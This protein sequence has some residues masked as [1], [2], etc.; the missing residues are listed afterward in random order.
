MAWLRI[1]YA[2]LTWAAC[3][4]YWLELLMAKAMYCIKQRDLRSS[5]KTDS[6]ITICICVLENIRHR[7][8]INF[9][10]ISSIDLSTFVALGQQTICTLPLHVAC[11]WSDAYAEWRWTIRQRRSVSCLPSLALFHGTNGKVRNNGF[12]LGRS[13]QPRLYSDKLRNE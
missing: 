8:D 12:G 5:F 6:G 9:N 2:N 11:T 10:L 4:V 7:F 1:T 3:A 13:V